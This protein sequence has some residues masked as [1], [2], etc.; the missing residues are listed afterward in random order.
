MISLLFVAV[1][2]AL[3]G[4]ALS[5]SYKLFLDGISILFVRISNAL[6]IT[7]SEFPWS[8]D[9]SDRILKYNCNFSGQGH[10]H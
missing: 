9:Y 5:Y 6:L 7:V 1:N 8:P 3:L 4:R 2:S 10:P